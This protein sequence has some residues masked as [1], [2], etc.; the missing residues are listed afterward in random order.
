[1]PYKVVCQGIKW[2]KDIYILKENDFDYKNG[3]N[4]YSEN[5]NGSIKELLALT[6]ELNK[7]AGRKINMK[8]I[9]L[10]FLYT[11]SR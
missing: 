2:V 11:H 5:T 8:K 9:Q 1:M 10:Y 6:N 3:M 4:V 7:V